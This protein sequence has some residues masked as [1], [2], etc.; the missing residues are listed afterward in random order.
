LGELL[1]RITGPENN[2]AATILH[3]HPLSQ[4]RLNYLAAQDQGAS[5]PAAL[6]E[7]EWAALKTTCE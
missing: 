2:G 6:G 7:A 5:G 3:D 1:L 4:Q